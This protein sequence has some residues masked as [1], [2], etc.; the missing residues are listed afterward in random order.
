M[1]QAR[2]SRS[3]D[4]RQVPFTLVDAGESSLAHRVV[5]QGPDV[6]LV[7]GWPLHSMTWRHVVSVLAKH[8]CCHVFDMPG[9][10]DTKVTAATRFRVDTHAQALRRAIDAVGIE[11][12]ALVGHDSGSAIA[13]YVAAALGERVWANVV[14]GSEIPKHHPLLLKVLLTLGMLPGGAAAM[15]TTLAS[16]TLRRSIF[17]WGACFHDVSR[18]EGEFHQLFGEPLVSD[19]RAFRGQMGLAAEF[20]WAL[21]DGLEGAHA[22]ITGPTLLLWGDRDPYFPAAKARAMGSQFAGGAKFV[23][24]PD[25]RLF[26][27]EEHPERFAAEVASFLTPLAPR[28]NGNATDPALIDHAEISARASA[29]STCPARASTRKLA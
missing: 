14:S 25:A 2:D 21:V 22:R 6:V 3:L 9:A 4:L 7:H 15:R 17:G 10:G 8:F 12:L 24:Y 1:T 5:G 16:P 13:R 28:V 20:D 26:V 29:G 19:E 27:H 11:R 23:S 18:A